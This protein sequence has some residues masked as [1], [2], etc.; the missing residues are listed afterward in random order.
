MARNYP[1][2]QTIMIFIVSVIV[3]GGFYVYANPKSAQNAIQYG[4]QNEARDGKVSSGNSSVSI[5][6]DSPKQI[7]DTGWQ[8]QFFTADSKGNIKYNQTSASGTPKPAPQ[9]L[10]DKI[11]QDL[12]TQVWQIHQAGLDTDNAALGNVTSNF[13]DQVAAA[14]APTMYS[15]KDMKAIPD[16]GN[17]AI[18]TYATNIMTVLKTIPLADAATIANNALSNNSGSLK[19]IDPI[20]SSYQA[21]LNKLKAMNVPSTFLSYHLNIVNAMSTL[22]FNAQSLR[23]ADIDPVRGLAAVS[24]YIQGMQQPSSALDDLSSGFTSAG[25]VFADSAS[26][27][28]P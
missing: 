9:T 27:N 6:N 1:R 7:A 17:S 28:T 15:A 24:I 16:A 14:A 22:L 2:M 18:A 12:F 19:E 10:T 3:V 26:S 8:K 21:I 13:A 23:K 4:S 25:I 11:S 5:G 20:I